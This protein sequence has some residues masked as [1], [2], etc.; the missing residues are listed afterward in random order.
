MSIKFYASYNYKKEGK[1]LNS[2]RCTFK[3]TEIE[4]HNLQNKSF[5][6]EYHDDKIVLYVEN[7]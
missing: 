4:K 3:K 2:F 1:S 7:K 5:N 6:I